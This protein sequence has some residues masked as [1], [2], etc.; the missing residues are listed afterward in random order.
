MILKCSDKRQQVMDHKFREAKYLNESGSKQGSWFLNRMDFFQFYT[1][2]KF[3]VHKWMSLIITIL[4]WF[5]LLKSLPYSFLLSLPIIYVA[6]V[7]LRTFIILHRRVCRYNG[8]FLYP[9]RF[10]KFFKEREIQVDLNDFDSVA[11]M[12]PK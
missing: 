3:A 2:P 9:K 6:Y 10:V 1:Y 4:S 8:Y 5:S 11:T 7:A 12:N